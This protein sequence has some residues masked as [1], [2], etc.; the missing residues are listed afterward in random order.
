M[1]MRPRRRRLVPCPRPS[2]RD[3]RLQA[4]QERFVRPRAS[5][6]VPGLSE[7][8]ERLRRLQPPPGAAA[9]AVAAPSPGD[10]LSWEVGFLFAELDTIE[11][12][13]RLAIT[14]ARSEAAA[15]EAA[16]ASEGRRLLERAA[17]DAERMASE[18]IEERRRACDRRVRELHGQ[19]DGEADRV[20][21][22]GR[23]RTPELVE[24][25]IRRIL[26]SP[27]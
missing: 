12:R 17:A 9:S 7:L 11:Q 19:A 8:L 24:E 18:L 27:A 25:V 23:D 1:G 22:N 21:A 3:D 15:I 26:E 20:L 16:A 10:A 6:D 14:A 5:L 4:V 2:L 13:R